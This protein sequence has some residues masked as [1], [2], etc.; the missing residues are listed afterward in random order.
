MLFFHNSD[1]MRFS[2]IA[3]LLLAG[4]FV[5]ATPPPQA[6]ND[7]EKKAQA[8]KEIAGLQKT[9]AAKLK[10][11]Q[12]DIEE[13]GGGPPSGLRGF[14]T[15]KTDTNNGGGND[16]DCGTLEYENGEPL[17][18][19]CSEKEH[20]EAWKKFREAQDAAVRE[21]FKTYVGKPAIENGQPQKP[22]CPET[23]D[24]DELAKYN[25]ME[26][27]YEKALV[28]TEVAEFANYQGGGGHG[29][30]KPEGEGQ[31][32]PDGGL[33]NGKP[34]NLAQD[35]GNTGGRPTRW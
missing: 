11:A 34:E 21:A 12:Q 30:N 20:P 29:N 15:E 22:K 19:N 24:P 4:S 3:V 23:G 26:K 8:L 13:K 14:E 31:K 35:D 9:T 6:N 33:G 7:K 27:A 10:Q 25:K 5:H 2:I 18:P 28:D 17:K 16:E 32:G 1:N